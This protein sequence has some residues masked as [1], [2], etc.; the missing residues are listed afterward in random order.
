MNE[1]DKIKTAEQRMAAA[2]WKYHPVTAAVIAWSGA[3]NREVFKLLDQID[4]SVNLFDPEMFPQQVKGPH[5]VVDGDFREIEE[6]WFPGSGI[7]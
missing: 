7:D 3:G 2:L 5:S 1:S 6:I 4:D